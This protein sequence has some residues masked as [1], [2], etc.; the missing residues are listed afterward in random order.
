MLRTSPC[1]PCLILSLCVTLH[2]VTIIFYY[3]PNNP[4]C[5]LSKQIN[6]YLF[7]RKIILLSNSNIL[8]P[9]FYQT[10]SLVFL[11]NKMI[12]HLFLKFSPILFSKITLL[13]SSKFHLIFNLLLF[14]KFYRYLFFSKKKKH[15]HLFFPITYLFLKTHPLSSLLSFHVY[16]SFSAYLL[17]FF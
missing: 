9:I 7:F 10:I 4:Q 15:L 3:H 17:G 16:P 12:S 13:S 8:S 5:F 11:K 14:Q 1:T 6:L 2:V